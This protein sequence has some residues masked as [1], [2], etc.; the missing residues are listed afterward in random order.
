MKTERFEMRL[1]INTL[2]RIDAW[3][4][5][6]PNRPSRAEAMRRLADA[7]LAVLGEDCIRISHGEK[8]ILVMLRDI[9]ERLN[10]KGDI[11]PDFVSEALG[12]GHHWALGW[13]Y[14]E[15]FHGTVDNEYAVE[16][17]V[18]A[19]EMWSQ[20]ELSYSKLSDKDKKE[21]GEK[22][23]SRGQHVKFPG[24]DVNTEIE[25]YSI[26]EF[27]IEH[28]GRFQEFKQHGLNSHFP[29]MEKYKSMLQIYESMRK[30]LIGRHLSSSEIIDLLNA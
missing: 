25:H 28:L 30:T 17:V 22:A 9:Y 19:L 3:R 6:Q 2:Q 14:R 21:V 29:C 20:I 16:E 10:V 4:A 11:A 13:K 5:E 15:L 27:L 26:C 12:G 18:D 7:G 23:K 24:F 1:D 8:L